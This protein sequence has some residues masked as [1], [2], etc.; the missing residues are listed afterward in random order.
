MRIK[1]SKFG[2]YS[3]ELIREKTFLGCRRF[4]CVHVKT[5]PY[6]VMFDRVCNE[7]LKRIDEEGNHTFLEVLN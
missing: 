1:K 4:V 5:G 3:G 6:I 2:H 7:G